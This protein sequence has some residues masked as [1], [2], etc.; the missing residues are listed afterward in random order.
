MAA[1]IEHGRR[2]RPNIRIIAWAG[3]A[4]LLLVPLVAMQVTQE[5]A[6]DVTDFAFFGGLLLSVGGAYEL[7]VRASG[8]ATYRAA[9]AIALAGVF[10]L[11]WVNA[12]VGIIGSE[13]DNANLLFAGVIATGV[14]GACLARLQPRGMARALVATAL[15]QALVGM[16]ALMG[17][18][19]VMSSAWPG[20]IFAATGFFAG[21]WLL[22]AW[23]F[24]RAAR[25]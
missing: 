2:S 19:G 23:L 4:A 6:W 7:L 25:A 21:L 20:D 15:A 13:A 8:N 17:R 24:G 11:V 18:L 10:L 5:V 22:S 3:A 1:G 12:A 16:V 14:A 9:A